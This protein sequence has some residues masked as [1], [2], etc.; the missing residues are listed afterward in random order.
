MTHPALAAAIAHEHER[1]LRVRA[2]R[3]R[4]AA[5]ARCCVPSPVSTALR[6][7]RARLEHHSRAQPASAAPEPIHTPRREDA[8]DDCCDDQCC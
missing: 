8:M 7:L 3:A 6:T 1:D 4:L 2:A 5:I